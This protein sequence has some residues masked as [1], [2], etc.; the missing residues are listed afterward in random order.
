MRDRGAI[1]AGLVFFLA[2]VTYPIWSG[3]AAGEGGGPPEL[4][5][6]PEGEKCVEETSA[7]RTDHMQLL[8]EWRDEVVRDNDRIYT[9]ADGRRFYKSLSGTCMS[10]HA[11]KE[12]FCDRCHNYVAVTPYCWDCHVEPPGGQRWD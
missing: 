12:Q 11:D 5:L 6:P 7:M 10:C 3:L 2:L 1:F 8:M 9:T 4:V